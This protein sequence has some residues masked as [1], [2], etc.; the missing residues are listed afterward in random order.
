MRYECLRLGEAP[1]GAS[2]CAKPQE[3][4]GPSKDKIRFQFKKC[5][6]Y[7]RRKELKE[8]GFLPEG[9]GGPLLRID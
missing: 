9:R 5:E 2:C 7:L 1:V 8:S 6:I 3:V 4:R